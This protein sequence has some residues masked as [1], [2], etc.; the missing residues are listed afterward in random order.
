LKLTGSNTR[1]DNAR[2]VTGAAG[3]LHDGG[4]GFLQNGRLCVAWNGLQHV[5]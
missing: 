5:A 4:G 3:F 1:T 2:I